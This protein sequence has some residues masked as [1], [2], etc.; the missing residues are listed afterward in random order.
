[1]DVSGQF[2]LKLINRRRGET[3]QEYYRA[4]MKIIFLCACAAFI[5]EIVK[6]VPVL[7]GAS[8]TALIQRVKD[9]IQK[10]Q[11]VNPAL[12]GKL[13]INN[14][15]NDLTIEKTLAKKI[16]GEYPQKGWS[17]YREKWKQEILASGQSELS[18]MSDMYI[19]LIVNVGHG[20]QYYSKFFFNLGIHNFY[21]EEYNEG[22]EGT[23]DWPY[24]VGPWNLQNDGK[25]AFNKMFEELIQKS[26]VLSLRFAPLSASISPEQ[27][28]G[29]VVMEGLAIETPESIGQGT[30]LFEGSTVDEG[31]FNWETGV[32]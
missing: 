16:P 31:G 4:N 29:Q 10:A 6:Q 1:M 12:A 24:M 17:Y 27:I 15:L 3:I 9:I 18:W 19:P 26:G 11:S 8:R 5:A 13:G 21:L 28:T 30:D 2:N 14:L 20:N 25:V 7:T 22:M 23:S 32:Q